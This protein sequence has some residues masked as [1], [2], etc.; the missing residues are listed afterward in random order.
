MDAPGG[1]DVTGV[2]R[3]AVEEPG[4]ATDHWWWTVPEFVAA[5]HDDGFRSWV[6]AAELGIDLCEETFEDLIPGL[7][8]TD[9]F[10]DAGISAAERAFLRRFPDH[11]A[12]A[13]DSALA[14]RFMRYLGH[15]WVEKLQCRWVCRPWPSPLPVIDCPW[16]T[17]QLLDLTAVLGRS[18]TDRR[19]NHWLSGFDHG[20]AHHRR[21]AAAGR[22]GFARWAPHETWPELD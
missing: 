14:F 1:V 13:A 21:W 22:P 6:I 16:P 3:V 18:V 17:D 9:P 19:G 8:V 11:A 7:P 2:G 12:L 5:Q 20:R 15:A 4:Q 10:G